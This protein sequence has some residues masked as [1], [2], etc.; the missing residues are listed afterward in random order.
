MSFLRLSLAG[1]PIVAVAAGCVVS[2]DSQ[3]HIVRDQRQFTV[4][5]TPDIRLTTFDGSIEVRSWDRPEVVVEIEK[6]GPTAEAVAELDVTAQQEGNR[7]Q[8]EVRRPAGDRS[9]LGIGLNMSRSARLVA[10]V[11]RRANVMAR[12]GD[13]AIRAE[14]LTGRVELRS[15]DGSVR[16]TGLEGDLTVHTGDGAVIL[17]A[18]SGRLNL[19][20][21]D[22][23]VSAAGQL[24]AVRAETGDGSI[25]LRAEPGSA[26][27]EDWSITTGD[28]GV[29]LYL[30]RAF[31]ANLDARTGDGRIRSDLDVS[32]SAG[33]HRERRS[34]TGRLGAGG[35]TLTIRT[36]D[37]GISLRGS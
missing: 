16:G 27:A 1:L 26:M 24:S 10:S 36:G 15:G 25:T 13:G 37:G 22:G 23:G 33:N 30:P 28:G 35:R 4:S 8:L 31:D 20:T 2:V 21:G 14:G 7:I 29:T 3:G 11:P 9:L 12:T 18:V 6:R 17:E 19:T 5:G 34:L 32:G